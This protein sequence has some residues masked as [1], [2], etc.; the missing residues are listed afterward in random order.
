MSVA[1]AAAVEPR[2]RMVEI[3]GGRHLRLVCVGPP[4]GARP[5]VLMEAGAFGFSA[6]WAAV[7]ERLAAQGLRSCAYDRAGLGH[8]DPGPKPRDSL[9]IVSDLEELLAA[10]DET[11]PFIL[12][13]HSMAGLHLRVFASRNAQRVRGVVLVDATTPEAMGAATAR[14]GVA[15]LV[16]F[17]RLAAWV[18]STGLARPLEVSLG[19]SIGLPP[20]AKAEKRWAFANG[21]HNR[22]SA[23]ETALW[24]IDAQEGVQSGPYNPDW[25]VA[26]ILTGEESAS[27]PR[28][29]VQSVPARA[30]KH[31]VV[32]YV[33]GA[34]HA[35]LLGETHAARV[36]E[37]ILDVEAAAAKAD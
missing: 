23:A 17:T 33:P 19:D 20:D 12:C 14:Q 37:A 25:P 2:G 26:V 4:A 9:A 28:Q 7:Q 6:D 13:G 5:T 34:N 35:S 27:G 15:Q 1:Y 22:W 8:S 21:P 10:A 18:V 32:L 29:V 36:V 3:E 11:G 31:G 16:L 30:S 24:T